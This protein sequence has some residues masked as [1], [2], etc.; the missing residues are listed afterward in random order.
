MRRIGRDIAV[1]TAILGISVGA[2]HG[3]N[4]AAQPNEGVP[5]AA[6]GQL[7]FAIIYSPGP[8]WQKGRPFREQIAI[9]EHYAHMKSLFA[10]GQTFVAGGLGADHGLVLLH[11]RDEAEA[12]AILAADPMIQAGVFVGAVERYSPSF[13]SDQPLTES[14]KQAF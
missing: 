8:K 4:A 7:L 13:L 9:K 1:V 14:K 5:A 3:Q 2:A 12:E 10:K 6:D 11:A